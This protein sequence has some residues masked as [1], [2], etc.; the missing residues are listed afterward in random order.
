MA[1][2]R[3][4]LARRAPAPRA[5]APLRPHHTY[6]PLDAEPALRL[7]RGRVQRCCVT[8]SAQV[9]RSADRTFTRGS[10]AYAAVAGGLEPPRHL[11]GERTERSGAARRAHTAG[12]AALHNQA[13]SPPRLGY[14][15]MEVECRV[16]RAHVERDAGAAERRHRVEDDGR[17]PRGP[18]RRQ[19]AAGLELAASGGG[20]TED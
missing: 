15:A 9:S 18:P 2:R 17:E 5:C 3:S 4:T 8:A 7:L 20:I 11:P 6:S 13:A 1:R 14:A 16:R 10:P 12:C 19:T